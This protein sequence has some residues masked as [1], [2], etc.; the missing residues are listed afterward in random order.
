[1]QKRPLTEEEQQ[2][3]RE[4]EAG[5]FGV[6]YDDSGKPYAMGAAKTGNLFDLDVKEIDDPHSRGSIYVLA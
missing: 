1:M 2:F 6:G 3:V 4:A 5:H